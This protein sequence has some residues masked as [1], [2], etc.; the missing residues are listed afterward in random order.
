MSNK[1]EIKKAREEVI[2]FFM[3]LEGQGCPHCDCMTVI[4][5]PPKEC[6]NCKLPV[7]EDFE[8]QGSTGKSFL[9]EFLSEETRKEIEKLKSGT[10]LEKEG[11]TKNV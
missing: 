4:G 5:K 11:E 8:W 1:T 3:K 6:P 9:E 7:G 2:N 10:L